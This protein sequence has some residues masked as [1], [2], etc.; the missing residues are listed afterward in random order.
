MC[1]IIVGSPEYQY[2]IRLAEVRH[3]VYERT[4]AIVIALISTVAYR[5]AGIGIVAFQFISGTLHKYTPPRLLKRCDVCFF[6]FIVRKIPH[7]ISFRL[8]SPIK[9]GI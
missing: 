8:H 9:C 1:P 3:A 7:L 2:Q 5:G 6:R 4:A